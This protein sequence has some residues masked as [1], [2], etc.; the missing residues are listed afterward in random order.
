MP[1]DIPTA[2]SGL[3]S[4]GKLWGYFQ[5]YL[6]NSLSTLKPPSDSGHQLCH[7]RGILL[8]PTTAAYQFVSDLALAELND[9]A[10]PTA[11]PEPSAPLANLLYG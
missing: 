10:P 1:K 4:F 3:T 6:Q 7:R 11:V 2:L 5:P 8:Y 9:D